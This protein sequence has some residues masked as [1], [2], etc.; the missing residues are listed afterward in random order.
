MREFEVQLAAG[1][2][3]GGQCELGPF[4]G[5]LDL[6]ERVTGQRVGTRGGDP[7]QGQR[8]GRHAD[9]YRGSGTPGARSLRAKQRLTAMGAGKL[10]DRF[11]RVRQGTQ[12]HRPLGGVS[13]VGLG[14]GPRPYRRTG[15]GAGRD[16]ALVLALRRRH[17]HG[18]QG[19][20]ELRRCRGPLRKSPHAPQRTY[21]PIHLGLRAAQPA[22]TAQPFGVLEQL[23]ELF[24]ASATEG[25]RAHRAP[26]PCEAPRT[27]QGPPPSNG[28]E[29]RLVTGLPITVSLSI[30]VESRRGAGGVMP[31]PPG[32]AAP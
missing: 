8:P 9:Q 26:F 3:R 12:T 10:A 19:L 29:T 2:V 5:P 27:A 24:E 6:V 4:A 31:A 25:V 21:A 11:R 1:L 32:T 17:E 28:S 14:G 13:H 15:C 18:P 23:G 30:T 20:P 22:V 16:E 7:G